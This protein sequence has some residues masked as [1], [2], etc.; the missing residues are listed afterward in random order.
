MDYNEALDFNA[1]IVSLIGE[2]FSTL[3]KNLSVIDIKTVL[4]QN[5]VIQFSFYNDNG[6]TL[7]YCNSI[8]SMFN[9]IE[10]YGDLTCLPDWDAE[11]WNVQ[12]I[13]NNPYRVFT[14]IDYWEFSD[15]LCDIKNTFPYSYIYRS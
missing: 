7:R 1:T 9:D 10:F 3:T 4:E 12:I 6:E 13:S 15:L 2:Q 5:W 8:G 11:V 14:L